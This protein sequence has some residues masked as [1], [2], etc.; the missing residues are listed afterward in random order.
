LSIALPRLSPSAASPLALLPVLLL[1]CL[2]FLQSRHRNPIPS[3]HSEWWAALLGL[4]AALCLILPRY[5]N[6]L[7]LPKIALLPALLALLILIQLNVLPK[8]HSEASLLAVLYLL[9]AMLLMVTACT[10]VRAHG[11]DALADTLALGIALG[12]LAST[13]IVA[14][15]ASD[16]MTGTRWVSQPYAGRLF[17]NLNQPNHLALQLWLGVASLLHL[18]ARQRLS[19]PTMLV[20]IVLL[21]GASLASGSRAIWLY[22]ATLVMLGLFVRWRNPGQRRLLYGAFLALLLTITGKLALPLLTEVAGTGQEKSSAWVREGSDNIRAGLWW[23][24]AR[25]GWENIWLGVGWG[26]F[27]S[28]SFARID[29]Y[30]LTAPPSLNLVAGEHAHSI[31][32][33]LWAELGALGPLLLIVTGAGWLWRSLRQPM[34]DAEALGI[35]LVLLLFVHAQIEYTLWYAYFLGIAAVALAIADPEKRPLPPIR[36]L[37]TGAILVAS[38]GVL[39]LLQHDYRRLENAMYWRSADPAA[40]QNWSSV[41]ADLVD[42]RQHSQFGGY[43][44]LTLIGAMPINL[45]ALKEKLQVCETGMAFSPPDYVVFKCAALL[46]LDGQK[47]AALSLFRRA[48]AAYPAKSAETVGWL[49]PLSEQYPAL[50]PLIDAANKL[51]A[52]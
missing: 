31:V 24:A 19:T 22:A 8:A 34:A 11:R 32:L 9:W 52:H 12:A 35:M 3:F 17:A 1:A 46:A 27:S 13:G 40:E 2:P 37:L 51:P 42:L 6:Q 7:A 4:V 44:D 30:L 10:M 26:S 29:T 33:N 5:R 21:T 18:H 50:R 25:M 28:A 15:Q 20:A 38:L 48:L 14:M 49:T 39:M 23:I 45:Q 36:P 41:I 43:V 47:D 16:V